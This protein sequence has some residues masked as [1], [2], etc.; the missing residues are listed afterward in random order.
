MFRVLVLKCGFMLFG[1]K[2]AADWLNAGKKM[3]MENNKRDFLSTASHVWWK[4]KWL[5]ICVALVICLLIF[6]VV[7][8][9]RKKDADIGL[10]YVGPM[11]LSISFQQLLEDVLQDYMPDT[12]GD[13]E[14]VLQVC[15]IAAAARYEDYP[16]LGEGDYVS[17][18]EIIQADPSADLEYSR[19]LINGDPNYETREAFNM[20]ITLGDSVIYFMEEYYY[21]LAVAMNVV[22]PLDT[23]LKE[24]NMPDNP[25]DEY[26]VWLKDLDIYSLDGF[27]KMPDDIIVC[28]RRFPDKSKNEMLYGRTEEEYNAHVQLFNALFAYQD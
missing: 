11:D 14:K 2:T 24:E 25:R 13:G 9:C 28:M 19:I 4:Y 3:N 22:A 8:G 23:V 27:E 15:S 1:R 5:I 16:L 17:D 20:E 18:G 7:S 6:S 10:M 12:N 21:D 26:S